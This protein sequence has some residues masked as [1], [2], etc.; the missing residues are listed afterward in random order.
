MISIAL[1]KC[2]R[3]ISIN[4]CIWAIWVIFLLVVMMKKNR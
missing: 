1:A 3:A 4:R 2:A